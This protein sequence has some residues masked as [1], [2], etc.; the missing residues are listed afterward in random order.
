MCVVDRA[1]EEANQLS[2]YR[3]TQAT[4]SQAGRDAVGAALSVDGV[5]FLDLD[6]ERVSPRK[7]CYTRDELTV[8]EVGR[9]RRGG[10]HVDLEV[11]FV[12]LDECVPATVDPGSLD[13]LSAKALQV[14]VEAHGDSTGAY[15]RSDVLANDRG[16]ES[17]QRKE[18]VCSAADVI[19]PPK[20]RFDILHR[21]WEMLRRS[22]CVHIFLLTHDRAF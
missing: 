22:R 3:D 18:R 13:V 8:G 14:R 1:A 9:Q 10:A 21:D 11:I 17:E 20:K 12:I 19:I 15:V 16:K 2:V 6:D 7:N 5:G 4:V